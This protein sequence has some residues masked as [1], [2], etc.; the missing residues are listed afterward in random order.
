MNHNPFVLDHIGIACE[1]ISGGAKFYQAL[2]F[3]EM[4]IEDVPTEKVK[5]GM[6]ELAN[7]SRIELLEPL[8][9]DSPIAKFLSKHGPGI[10][11]I[12]FRVKGIQRILDQ[13]KSSGVRLIHEKPTP[14]AHGCMVAF[15]HPHSTGGVLIELSE[16]TSG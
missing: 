1:S 3:N 12:C 8:S 4:H 14:G 7:Q 15:I 5:V 6:Y 16:K 9:P 11:H 13:L 10:H 2:G